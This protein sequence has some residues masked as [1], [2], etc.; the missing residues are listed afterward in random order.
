MADTDDLIEKGRQVR[1][2]VL[3][4]GHAKRASSGRNDFNAD[5]QDFLF[6]Y[7]WAET[8]A[9]PGLDKKT[10]SMITIAMLVAMGRADELKLHVRATEHTGVTKEEM[11]EILMHSTIYAGVPAAFS[12]FQVAAQ[13]YAEM[14]A[15]AQ[16]ETSG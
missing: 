8:W 3:G 9:R 11:K 16:S 13:T 15:E 2:G 5:F 12:A 14:E 10:R 7:A 6:K 4:P 1:L